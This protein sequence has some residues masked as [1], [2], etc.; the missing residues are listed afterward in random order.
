MNMN[1][2]KDLIKKYGIG[3]ILG[4]ATLD[5]YRRQVLNDRKNNVLEVIKK[6]REALSAERR[7]A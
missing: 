6:E 5:G 4:A 1:L 2:F 3:M 7:E